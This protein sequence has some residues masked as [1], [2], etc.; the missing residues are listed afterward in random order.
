[1][2]TLVGF[3]KKIPLPVWVLICLGIAMFYLIVWPSANNP[4]EVNSLRY[5]VL[6]WFHSLTWIFLALSCFLRMSSAPRLQSLAKKV[7]FLV[8]PTYL[9]FFLATGFPAFLS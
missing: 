8:L 3:F 1:M 5:S 4:G 6:R 9:L 2:R 7:A